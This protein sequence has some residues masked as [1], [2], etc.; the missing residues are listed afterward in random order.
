M[1]QFFKYMLASMLGFSITI[2]IVFL[3]FFGIIASV[4]SS[5]SKPLDAK[6]K[7]NSILKLKFDK[8]IVD[9]S[10][11]NPFEN[12]DFTT[13]KSNNPIGLKDIINSIEK[14]KIDERIKGIY[15]S[16]PYLNARRANVEEIRRA[17][18]SFKESGKFII[19]YSEDFSQNEY[20]L[21]SVADEIYLNPAGD[22]SLKGLSAQVMFFKEALEKLEVD[23]QVVRHGKFKSAVEPFIRNDMS[24]A[25]REQVDALVQSI[26]NSHLNVISASRNISKELLNTLADSLS[27][28]KAED[29]LAHNLVDGLKYDDEVQELLKVKLGVEKETAINWTDLNEMKKVKLHALLKKKNETDSSNTGKYQFNSKNNLAIIYASGEIVSGESKQDLMGSETIAKALK[30]A[31]EDE[32]VKAIVFRVNSPGGSALASDVIWREVSLAKAKKPLVVSMGGVAASGGYYISCAADKIY[33]ENSTITGSI[34]VFGLIPNMKGLFNHKMGIHLDQVNTNPY[35]D[36]LSG[37]RPMAEQERIAIQESIENIYDKFT[38]KVAK[39]RGMTQAEV[40]SIGQGRVWTGVLA[41]EIGLVDEIG[42]MED[43][44]S[45]AVE[46]AELDNYK[47]VDL[48]EQEDPFQMM[49]KEFSQEI[50]F[51]LMQDEFG[52]AEKYY[53]NLKQALNSRGIYTRMPV[54]IMIE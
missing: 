37:F 46:L 53:H 19:S 18:A 54:E 6:V 49:M 3:I 28:R 14:A 25:N 7:E 16:I 31:R 35:A 12:F 5:S 43:A 44:I 47:I 33:A 17:L 40:D 8:A 42:G 52:E 27:I 2:F 1:K 51:K 48:P 32:R 26:W 39:G 34:G 10:S 41:K 24:E 4:I 23:L 13:L 22:F 21:S 29:A 30:E 50:K 11:N 36:G 9:R 45:A 20:Y 15:L 38:M